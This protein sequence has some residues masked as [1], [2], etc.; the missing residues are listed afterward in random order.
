MGSYFADGRGRARSDI[1]CPMKWYMVTKNIGG[2]P[3]L[4][5]QRTYR[6]GGKVRTQCQYVGAAGDHAI[7]VTPDLSQ[8][9]VEDLPDQEELER[10]DPKSST[11]F[12]DLQEPGTLPIN[13]ERSTNPF[14]PSQRKFQA[15]RAKIAL[16]R[17]NISITA[18]KS[19]Y[20]RVGKQ[21]DHLGLNGSGLATIRL[22]EGK[23]AGWKRNRNGYRVTLAPKG[24]GSGRNRFKRQ[25]RLALAHALLDTI[26]SQSPSLYDSLRTI[27][28]RSWFNTKLLVTMQILK[29]G[30]KSR[31]SKGSKKGKGTNPSRVFMALQFLWSGEVPKA[32]EKQLGKTGLQKDSWSKPA[33]WR[34]EAA[35]LIAD[36]IQRGYGPSLKR[37]SKDKS[38][39]KAN[40]KRAFTAYRK[41]NRLQ[42]MTAKG[43]KTWKTYKKHEVMYL[44]SHHRQSRLEVL[45]PFLGDFHK[46]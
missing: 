39:A 36:V 33:A 34:D 40:A 15:E 16:R 44:L 5:R 12:D 22:L 13:W 23:T 38:R 19:E 7:A 3:Y 43:R 46:R 24:K 29:Q 20:A 27:M 25:Y 21:I 10:A 6:E 37:L 2:R 32:L 26:E 42:R 28:D 35:T 14:W 41:L 9:A 1:L 31:Q 17:D 4:Y 45:K 30:G 11:Q 8:V 18:M